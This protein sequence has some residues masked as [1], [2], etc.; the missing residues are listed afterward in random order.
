MARATILVAQLTHLPPV[1]ICCGALATRVRRQEFRLNGA[2]SAAVLAVSTLAGGLAW[3]ER[4]IALALP[5]CEYHRRQVRR[6]TRTLIQGMALT[7]GLGAASY[8]ATQLDGPAG[9]YLAV[10]AM[11]AFIVTLLVGMQE[12]DDGLKVKSLTPD[13]VTIA[14]VHRTF[15]EAVGRSSAAPAEFGVAPEPRRLNG[16]SE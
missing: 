12:V 1:C 16:S 2:L 5:V 14:G 6:S 9:N 15:A 13:A 4:G 3:T 11:F 7:G 10:A 8:L